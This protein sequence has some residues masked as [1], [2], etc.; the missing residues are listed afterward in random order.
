MTGDSQAHVA[1][2]RMWCGSAWRL[3]RR[4]RYRAEPVRRGNRVGRLSGA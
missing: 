4:R 2:E 3:G 1:G